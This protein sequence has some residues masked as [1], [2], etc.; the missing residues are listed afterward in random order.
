MPPD[1]FS[2]H[3]LIHI[4]YGDMDT[5]GHVNNAKYLTYIEQARLGL[6]RDL[7]LWTGG[8]TPVGVIVAKITME[9]KLPL[10]LDDATVDIWTRCSRLGGKSFDIEQ[11]LL[12]R[13]GA[14]AANSQSVMVVYDYEANATTPLPAEWRARLTERM[15]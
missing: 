14:I 3:T 15:K 6:F 4:R 13:D 9:Y 7:G 1:G 5:L 2:Y 11:L 8:P 12:R 10:T